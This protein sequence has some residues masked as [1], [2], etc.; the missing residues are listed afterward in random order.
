MVD[1][2]Q[3]NLYK[4]SIAKGTIQIVKQTAVHRRIVTLSESDYDRVKNSL[5]D[6]LGL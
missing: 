6:I 1:W 3:A 4:P 2:Q 5:R